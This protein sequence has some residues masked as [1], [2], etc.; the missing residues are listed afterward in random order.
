M[1][2]GLP[3]AV[4]VDMLEKAGSEYTVVMYKAN[5]PLDGADDARVIR[6]KVKDG[7]YE[8]LVSE[9]K[10]DVNTTSQG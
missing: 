2:L 9:F 10:T 8:L 3:L 5:R 1:L 7:V 6:T 4:A